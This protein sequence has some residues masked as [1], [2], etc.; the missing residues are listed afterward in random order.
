MNKPF[1]I[2]F[3]I[4]LAFK[5]IRTSVGAC[6]IRRPIGKLYSES[7]D[8]NGLL[9]NILAVFVPAGAGN[10]VSSCIIL[11][12]GAVST[13]LPAL[14]PSGD[15]GVSGGLSGVGEISGNNM[16]GGRTPL[17]LPP[18][19]YVSRIILFDVHLQKTSADDS[20]RGRRQASWSLFVAARCDIESMP[21]VID[22]YLPAC[23][24]DFLSFS[25]RALQGDNMPPDR[26]KAV[27]FAISLP[28]MSGAVPCTASKIATS[29]PILT[30]LVKPKPPIKPEHVSEIMSPYKFG[31]TKTS[32]ADGFCTILRQRV[33]RCISSN[34]MSGYC[35]ASSLALFKN[36][37][38]ER[39]RKPLPTGV[40]SGPLRPIL[41][42]L[43]DSNASGGICILPLASSFGATDT[44]SHSIGTLIASNICITAF[45]ISGPT[46]SPSTTVTLYSSR[47]TSLD[48][49]SSESVASTLRLLVA[50]ALL[51]AFRG[52]LNNKQNE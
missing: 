30:E 33:P 47:T 19:E 15:T 49:S 14:A 5:G 11:I 24:I 1:P 6:D 16:L 17:T 43:N 46:P 40:I 39:E 44:V 45:V 36:K 18:S 4:T 22:I 20:E 7:R 34:L 52:K 28:A 26:S 50:P 9:G 27:G 10:D 31:I 29:S 23:I 32:Y 48:P 8:G 38:S 13:P 21:V 41:F 12:E 51:V 25:R 3:G 2:C 42:L 35:L 37:P